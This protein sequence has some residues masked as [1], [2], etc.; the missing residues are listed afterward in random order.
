MRFSAFLIFLVLLTSCQTTPEVSGLNGDMTQAP[1]WVSVF[2]TFTS[3]TTTSINIL[4]PH[5]LEARYYVVED[6][7]G[8][9]NFIDSKTLKALP[10]FKTIKGPQVHWHVDQ[11]HVDR[12]K[13]NQEYQLLIYNSRSSKPI[14]WRRFHTLDIQKKTARFVVGSCMSDSHA[15]EHVRRQI[16]PLM[17]EKKPD[18]IMLLGDQ[19]YVDDFDFVRREQAT[20]YDLWSRYIDSFRKIPLFQ[21]RDLIPIYAVWDDHD[22]GTNNS[23][24]NFKAKN[25]ARKV[26]T[27]FFGGKNIP[28]IIEQ[29]QNGV[30]ISFR[31][32]QQTFLLMDNR[33][34]R[35]PDSKNPY[36]QWGEKQH[37]WFKMQLQ[38]AKT[39]IWL[40]NGGQFF[41]RATVVPVDAKTTKQINESFIDDHPTHFQ[42]IIEDLKTSPQP[43]AFLSGDVHYSEISK[44]EDTLLGYPT[45]E[46]TSSPIHSY[47]YRAPDGSDSWLNNPRRYVAA[48][49]HNFI[50]IDSSANEKTLN[51]RVRSFGVKKDEALFDKTLTIKKTN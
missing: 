18:F 28:N 15:F 7:G 4:R 48:K 34:F 10:V 22:F 38:Q 39:P 29:D 47:I 13:P 20:E 45:Y 42:K 14:D 11:L 36:G 6:K 37:G 43:L 50:V 16:W 24:K 5:L 19:V 27:A 40:A 35:D 41:T 49:D 2:Q 46:I 30:Y 21:Q 26:F 1:G 3:D 51:M 12:L 32:F 9:P 23:N 25:P 8:D 17:S 33:Y 31:A 44:I